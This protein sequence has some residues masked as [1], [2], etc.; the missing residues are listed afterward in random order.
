MAM[1]RSPPRQRGQA[2]VLNVLGNIEVGLGARGRR[3]FERSRALAIELDFAWGVAFSLEGL[4][5]LA[6]EE[7]QPQ[8]ALVLAGAAERRRHEEPNWPLVLHHFVRSIS[9]KRAIAKRSL[10]RRSMT[11]LF[12]WSPDHNANTHRVINRDA[13]QTASSEACLVIIAR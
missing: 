9:P 4:A 6:V 12:I 7:Q 5:R 11:G 3:C 10:S 1:T 2:R 8:R 13:E